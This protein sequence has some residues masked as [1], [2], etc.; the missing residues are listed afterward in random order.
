M[1]NAPRPALGC[2][3]D[4]YGGKADLE[5]AKNLNKEV[6]DFLSS[7]GS[8]YGIGFWKPGSGIIHQVRARL[9]A[10]GVR[11]AAAAPAMRGGWWC[12]APS[13]ALPQACDSAPMEGWQQVVAAVPCCWVAL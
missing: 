11:V 3:N 10:R 6:Y 9:V 8:K 7:A 4:G 5:Y 13:S 1:H 12:I 2:R